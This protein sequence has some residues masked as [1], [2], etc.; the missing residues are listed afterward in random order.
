MTQRVVRI[1]LTGGIGAGKSAVASA[2][3]TL[4]CMVSDSD[5]GARAALRSAAVIAELVKWW[6]EQI[7]GP[8]GTPDRQAIARIVFN[9]A[10]ERARLEGLIHPILHREREEHARRA[11]AIGAPALIVDAPLLLEAGLDRECDAV[12]FVDTPR[13][14][15]LARVSATR[16]WDGA[17]LDR[18]EAAQLPLEEK[19]RRSG[20][21]IENRGDREALVEAARRVLVAVRGTTGGGLP[22]AG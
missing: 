7:L 18:R 19:R 4:G 12:V 5:A 6:G 17:E 3:A 8:D 15:R 21:V 20:Y 1:G 16:G 11:A 2:F 9:D 13:D 10:S 14:V 22:P